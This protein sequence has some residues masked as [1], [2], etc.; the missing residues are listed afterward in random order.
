MY[1]ITYKDLQYA[2]DNAKAAA[3]HAGIE[4]VHGYPIQDMQ[5]DGAYGATPSASM[6]AT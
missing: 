4:R 6:D 5:L 3:R 1:R 2:L